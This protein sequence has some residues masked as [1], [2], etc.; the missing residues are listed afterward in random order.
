[1]ALQK[2]KKRKK[3]LGRGL[4]SLIPD[5]GNEAKKNETFFDCDV[6]VISP[7]RYQPRIIFDDD[8]MEEL[9]NSV[10]EQGIIQALVVR[11]QDTGYEL[12]V[13]ERRL[14]AAKKLGL[15]KVP[16]VVKKFSDSE[17][18]ELSIVENIQRQNLLPIEEANAYHRLMNEFALTQN[19]VAL[20]VGK[21]RSAVANFLRL[22]ELPDQIKDEIGKQNLSM[23]H[24]RALLALEL[25]A[26]Q[27]AACKKVIAKK[28]SVRETENLVKRLS[29]PQLQKNTENPA[30]PNRNYLLHLAEDISGRLSRK[31]KIIKKGKKGKLEIEFYGD[32]DL[33]RFID[34]LKGFAD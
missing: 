30:D 25:Q 27:I 7:N 24:A 3:V 11:E 23:G 17:M 16:V 20:R 33:E 14:R 8:S 4:D 5:M 6:D 9:C 28:L 21:S 12:V 10:K 19:D 15:A 1:M 18:L 34:F 29:R 2:E 22:R 32:K 13:G 31:V 26:Q